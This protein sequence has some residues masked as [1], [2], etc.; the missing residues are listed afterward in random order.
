M[1]DFNATSMGQMQ[2]SVADPD[3]QIRGVGGHPDPDVRGRGGL[4]KFFSAFRLLVWSRNKGRPD[5]LPPPPG[6]LSWIRH[7]KK[8]KKKEEGKKRVVSRS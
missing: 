6:F 4:K 5:P 8:K 3:F 1:S 2:E 7:K